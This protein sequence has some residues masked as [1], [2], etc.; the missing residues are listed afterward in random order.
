MMSSRVSVFSAKSSSGVSTTEITW[1]RGEDEKTI[2]ELKKKKKKKKKKKTV[3]VC[4]LPVR[5]S[6]YQ[7]SVLFLI[8]FFK[9]Q[10]F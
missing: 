7:F 1:T 4:F 2:N 9:S 10:S 6:C 3:F 5:F 8:L